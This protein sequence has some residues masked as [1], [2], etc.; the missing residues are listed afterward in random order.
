M[1]AFGD[2][3]TVEDGTRRFLLL[4]QNLKILDKQKVSGELRQWMQ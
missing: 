3:A 1:E 4:F 2:M